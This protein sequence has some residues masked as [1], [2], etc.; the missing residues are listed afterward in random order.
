MLHENYEFADYKNDRE[1]TRHEYEKDLQNRTDVLQNAIYLKNEQAENEHM[2]FKILTD[3]FLDPR[4]RVVEPKVIVKNHTIILHGIVD[5]YW[6]K[7]LIEQSVAEE[8]GHMYVEN[9]LTV[10]PSYRD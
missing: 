2:K 3:I 10:I 7:A 5:S 9:N 4:I 1:L 8:A 6:K